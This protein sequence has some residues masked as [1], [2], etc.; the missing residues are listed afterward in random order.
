MSICL[1]VAKV[2]NDI[3]LEESY[4]WVVEEQRLGFLT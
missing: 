2:L 4:Q 3:L 1:V